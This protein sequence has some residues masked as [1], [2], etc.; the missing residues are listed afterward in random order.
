[1]RNCINIKLTKDEIVMK[2]Q[3]DSEEEQIVADLDKKLKE[4]K[5]L[6][7]EAKTPILV[8]GKVLTNK[9]M[10]SVK[11]IIEK[12]IPVEVRFDSPKDLG[13]HSIKRVFNKEIDIST[14]KFYKGSLRS[15][16]KIEFEGS[17][18]ILG[19]VNAGSEVMASDNIVVLGILRGLAHAGAKGNKRAIIAAEKIESPQIR[20]ANV[21]K[22]LEKIEE[23]NTKK[24]AYVHEEEIV[25]E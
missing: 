8:T 4:L 22:E 1:M 16:Q 23:E 15:G 11:K 24:Y 3:E 18:I 25:L 13:L 20:I 21:V 6:Y 9:E 12:I 5:G 7:K 14:S 10:E 2:I 19:D 17:L